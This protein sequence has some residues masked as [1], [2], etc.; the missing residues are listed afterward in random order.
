MLRYYALRMSS[1]GLKSTSLFLLTGILAAQTQTYGPPWRHTGTQPVANQT[2][3]LMTGPMVVTATG[4]LYAANTLA[5]VTRAT[6]IVGD[7]SKSYTV[8][9][10]VSASSG[11]GF[12]VDIGGSYLIYA[13]T[14]DRTGNVLIA[15]KALPA[16]LPVAASAFRPES[17]GDQSGF[18]CKLNASDGSLVFCTYLGSN[19]VDIV[20]VGTDLVGN[21]YVVVNQTVDPGLGI[22][23]SLPVTPGAV[24]LGDRQIA[25]IKVDPTGSKLLYT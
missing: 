15:G 5:G 25:V 21:V 12:A 17:A 9:S 14:V 19:Q 16:G 23:P 18:L 24:S 3:G 2:A 11:A 20:A 10:K 13:L 1:S 22:P 8:I 6:R 7:V 4:D